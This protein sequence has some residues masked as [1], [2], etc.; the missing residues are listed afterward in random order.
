MAT[1]E[2]GV[3]YQDDYTKIAD[4]LADMKKMAESI[5]KLIEETEK[6]ALLSDRIDIAMKQIILNDNAVVIYESTETIKI[7][8]KLTLLKTA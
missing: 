2:K 5:D 6:V 7:Y 8:Y 3:Y 4:I 1:T